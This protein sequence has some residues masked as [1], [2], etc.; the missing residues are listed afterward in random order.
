MVGYLQYSVWLYVILVQEHLTCNKPEIHY[1]STNFSSIGL[2]TGQS[3]V[4]L[5]INIVWLTG[6]V[7]HESEN[8]TIS[9][10][11]IKASSGVWSG[12]FFK[13]VVAGHL[14]NRRAGPY[15]Y[16]RKGFPWVL[17]ASLLRATV[18]M[19]E[20]VGA[21]QDPPKFTSKTPDRRFPNRCMYVC[22]YVCARAL[23]KQRF[24]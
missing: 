9:Y 2:P 7:K 18:H 12:D 22:M 17:P 21:Q 6:P 15:P 1:S 14:G 24:C 20:S 11:C 3:H 19:L 13:A 5:Q 16:R 10:S 4:S 8:C 23:Q